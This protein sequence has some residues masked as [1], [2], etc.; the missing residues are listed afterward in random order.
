MTRYD[1]WK[2]S[3]PPEADEEDMDVTCKIKDDEGQCCPFEGKVTAMVDKHRYYWACPTC[4][5][6]H[7]E[8]WSE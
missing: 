7:E 3:G 2:L 4:D 5:A 1:D 8:E 6:D